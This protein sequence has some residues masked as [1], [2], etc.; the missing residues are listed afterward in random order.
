MLLVPRISL[1]DRNNE[2][3]AEIRNSRSHSADDRN[4]R[5]I[6]EL[7]EVRVVVLEYTEGEGKAL[8]GV[9]VS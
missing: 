7:W 3:S 5:A 4:I 8:C 6:G 2:W 9:V 1:D